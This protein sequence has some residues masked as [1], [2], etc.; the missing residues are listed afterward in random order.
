MSLDA[1]TRS[2]IEQALSSRVVGASA[3]GG[4]CIAAVRRVSLAD[5]REVVVKHGRGLAL[6]AWMLRWLAERTRAPVPA[7]L[8]ADDALLILELL[9]GDSAGLSAAAEAQLGEIVANLH[10]IGSDSFGFER[11]TVIGSLSQPNPRRPSW[12]EFFRGD[13]LLH[14]ADEAVGA[15]RL[16][17]RTRARVDALAGRL[18]RWIDDGA[19]PSLIHGDLWAGNILSR[20]GRITGL[21]DPA[22]YFADPEIELAFMTLFGSV[23]EA[24][25]RSYGERRPLRPGFFEARRDLYNLYPLLVHVRLFGGSY[26]AQVER[27]LDKFGV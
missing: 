8:H 14:M 10:S 11:D 6:E 12:R 9:E 17:T 24:F 7:V 1:A 2:A 16:P 5:G 25:F 20:G 19:R 26:A 21:I 23:G 15:G 22:L 13:R 27:T 4:G 18:E 3:M